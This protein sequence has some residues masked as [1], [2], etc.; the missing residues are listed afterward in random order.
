MSLGRRGMTREI[1]EP[2]IPPL[3]VKRSEARSE[4]ALVIH[5]GPRWLPLLWLRVI[6]D[7]LA[8]GGR[9]EVAERTLN[10]VALSTLLPLTER[11]L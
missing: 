11:T 8:S 10:P 3:S 1:G 2:A 4:E 7:Y 5:A 9:R 6:L